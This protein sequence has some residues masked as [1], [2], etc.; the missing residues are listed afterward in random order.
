MLRVMW[1]LQACAMLPIF[2]YFIPEASN[3]QGGA[4]F[5]IVLYYLVPA[6]QKSMGFY[7]GWFLSVKHKSVVIKGSFTILKK[8][9]GSSLV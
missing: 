2:V 3:V 1:S 6:E 7:L 9:H 8:N 4:P 5:Q